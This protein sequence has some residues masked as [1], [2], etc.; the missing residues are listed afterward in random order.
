MDSVRISLVVPAR[1]EARLLP[2][3]LASVAVARSRYRAGASAVEVILADNG[4]S[5]ETCAIARAAGC[6]VVNV[7][8]RVIAAV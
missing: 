7:E 5:D 8:P 3:L 6:V 4:S 2:R 1:N